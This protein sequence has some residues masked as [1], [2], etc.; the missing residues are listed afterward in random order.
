MA[1]LSARMSAPKKGDR[2]DELQAEFLR[3]AEEIR[4]LKNT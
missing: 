4:V 3:L 1:V 2:P